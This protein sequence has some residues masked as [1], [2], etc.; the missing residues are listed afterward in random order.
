MFGRRS[1]PLPWCRQCPDYVV[2][3]PPQGLHGW[4]WQILVRQDAHSSS[5]YGIYPF[6]L[7]DLTR[8]LEACQNVF[9]GDSRIAV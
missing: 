6:G 3:S 7:E 9:A 4:T 2:P 1:A 5:R 8:V